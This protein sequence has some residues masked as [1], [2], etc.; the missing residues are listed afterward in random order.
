MSIRWR[1][2]ALLVGI[3]VFASAL[4]VILQDR[5]LSRDLERNAVARLERSAHS[6]N[7]LVETHLRTLHD[8]YTAISG[9]PQFRAN[10]EVEDPPTLEHYAR[11]LLRK[12]KAARILFFDLDGHI[13]ASAGDFDVEEAARNVQGSDL[14]AHQGKPFAVVSVTL[15]TRGVQVGRLVA[16]EQIS[17]S[18]IDEWSNLCG[19]EVMFGEPPEE[20]D[21]R[22]VH[23]VR[24]LPNLPLY[25]RSSLEAE[26]NASDRSRANLLAAG[27]ITLLAV[28]I[29]SWLLA[30]WLVSGILALK[31]AAERIGR[32]DFRARVRLDRSDEIGAV[33]ESVNEMASHLERHATTLERKNREL[34]TVNSDLVTARDNAEA[35][36]RAKSDFLAN[37]SHEIRT[38]MTAILGYTE[39]LLDDDAPRAERREWT[40]AVRRNGDYLLTLINSILDIST[41][42]NAS[43][44]AAR[45]PTAP[46]EIVDEVVEMMRAEAEAKGLVLSLERLP[47]VPDRIQTNGPRLRQVVTQLL[48]NAIK[49]TPQ[50]SVRVV[51]RLEHAPG[52]G[53]PRLAIDVT[54]TGIG[55]RPHDIERIFEPFTQ[56]DSSSTRVFGGTGLG[57]AIAKRVAEMLGGDV[58]VQSAP[59]A[60]STFTVHVDTGP[61]EGGVLAPVQPAAADAGLQLEGRVLLAEDN[62]DN[63][64]LIRAL[65][66]KAGIELETAENGQIAVERALYARDQGD[67]FDLIIMD[68]QMPVL[69]G[70]DATRRLRDA[71]YTGAIIA[72]TAHAMKEDREKCLEAGCDDFATKP[73]DRASL[74]ETV[75]PYVR[76]TGQP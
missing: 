3:A 34:V 72:L 53:A 27:S 11:E 4:C 42:E 40:D 5:A 56:V 71:G 35:A 9:T 69:D 49:F 32:G 61:L 36:S 60:G 2:L 31:D 45:S 43:L 29:A 22:I 17:A 37:M 16:V 23:L 68:M 67:P 33:A 50:G 73:I 39:L 1:I 30:N 19:A 55:V 14:I 25:V 63:R 47:G 20:A 8:V 13:T 65:L 48:N 59:G 7:L 10:L 41:I 26:R 15:A 12:Q 38:P 66:G 54:D 24:P 62:R 52:T 70:Y 74:I 75:T 58:T 18:T 76:K 21:R 57:L 44:H 6:S 28:L 46:Y 64:R 51:V